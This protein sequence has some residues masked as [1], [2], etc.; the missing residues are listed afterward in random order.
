MPA[1]ADGPVP[2]I[3]EW[4]ATLATRDGLNLHVRPLDLV[5]KRLGDR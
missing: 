2:L 3:S 5:S 4:S 1:L